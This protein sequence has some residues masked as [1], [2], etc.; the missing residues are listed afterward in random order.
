MASEHEWTLEAER[1]YVTEGQ[2]RGPFA[3]ITIN[4]E[5]GGRPVRSARPFRLNLPEEKAG[6]DVSQLPNGYRVQL[7]LEPDG[8][9]SLGGRATRNKPLAPCAKGHRRRSGC[10]QPPP[11][12]DF[13]KS[14]PP[15]PLP[16]AS[17]ATATTIFQL[18]SSSVSRRARFSATAASRSACR[19]TLAFSRLAGPL[20]P[21]EQRAHVAEV[22][23]PRRVLA[24]RRRP[25]HAARRTSVGVH[26]TYPPPAG[27]CSASRRFARVTV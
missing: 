3:T 10:H 24:L 4:I 22:R 5:R 27:A 20:Q 21:G 12:I 8:S 19:S 2:I 15:T 11:R 26:A 9:L 14:A 7:W 17:T 23:R 18:G 6:D 25:H 1:G 13:A 16:A